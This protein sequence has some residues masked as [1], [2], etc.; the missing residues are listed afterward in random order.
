MSSGFGIADC[1]CTT[2]RG[3][4][5]R[6]SNLYDQCLAPTGLRVTQ[7]AI[8][9]VAAEA[10]APSVNRLA[11]ILDLDRTTIG[12]NLRPLEREC[13]IEIDVDPADRR[14]RLVRVSNRG[15][16]RLSQALPLWQGAQR[17]FEKANG[18]ARSAEIRST[19]AGLATRAKMRP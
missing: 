16:T 3:A 7:F 14:T 5:R 18:V 17:R 4:S 6:I 12:K 10:A 19:L 11:S 2:L 9:A 15:L 8:L 1:H 13:L